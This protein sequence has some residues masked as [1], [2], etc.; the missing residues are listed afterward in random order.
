MIGKEKSNQRN[1]KKQMT[2]ASYKLVEHCQLRKL[3]GWRPMKTGYISEVFSL[4]LF[5][6]EHD[7]ATHW[8]SHIIFTFLLPPNSLIL[9]T[10]KILDEIFSTLVFLL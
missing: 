5:P 2:E 9:T 7:I 1:V 3:Q 8:H 10:K 4:S 6:E